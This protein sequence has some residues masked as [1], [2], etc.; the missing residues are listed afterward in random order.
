MPFFIDEELLSGNIC[1]NQNIILFY[2]YRTSLRRTNSLFMPILLQ[3][4]GI[5][6]SK[7]K[8]L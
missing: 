4:R 1:E 5:F 8:W 6:Y 7:M 3:M 2:A